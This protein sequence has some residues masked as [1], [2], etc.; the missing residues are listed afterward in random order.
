MCMYEFIS[1][2]PRRR[3]RRESEQDQDLGRPAQTGSC[4]FCRAQVVAHEKSRVMAV[5]VPLLFPWFTLWH[6][7]QLYPA[8]GSDVNKPVECCQLVHIQHVWILFFATLWRLAGQR[9]Y[10]PG[11]IRRVILWPYASS[12]S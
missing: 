4:E 1:R 11:Q 6:I 2:E 10:L 5:L 3:Q 7:W 8:D 9:C 12:S